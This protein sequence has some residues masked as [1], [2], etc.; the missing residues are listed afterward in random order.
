MSSLLIKSDNRILRTEVARLMAA[1]EAAIASWEHFYPD[2]PRAAEDHE[3]GSIL[4]L[5]SAV[6]SARGTLRTIGAPEP[7]P[8]TSEDERGR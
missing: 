1:G 8:L 4:A 7:H 6:A 5:R 3:F 2:M